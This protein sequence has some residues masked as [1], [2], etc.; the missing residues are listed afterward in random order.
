MQEQL[1]NLQK[2]MERRRKEKKEKGIPVKKKKK[3]SKERILLDSVSTPPVLPP[4]GFPITPV[5]VPGAVPVSAGV[6]AATLP[7]PA[8]IQH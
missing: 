2:D 4:T 3:S 7:P 6:P 5:S 1:G 8:V